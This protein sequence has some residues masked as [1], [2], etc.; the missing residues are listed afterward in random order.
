MRKIILLSVGISLA[1]VDVSPAS[2]QLGGLGKRAKEAVQRKAEQ[3]AGQKID[4]AA[5]K[6]V[7]RSFDSIFGDGS[8]SESSGGKSSKGSSRIFAMLP[9]AATED[10]YDFDAVLT[11]KLE[12]MPKGKSDGNEILMLMHFNSNQPYAGTRITSADPKRKDEGEAFIILD[13]KNESMV[14]L[15]ESGDGKFSM[16]YSWKDAAKYAN[17]NAPSSPSPSASAP[18][19][20]PSGSPPPSAAYSKIGSK[21]IAGYTADGYRQETEQS[22][23]DVWVSQDPSIA[24]SNMMGASSSMKQVRGAVPGSHPG[25]MLLETLTIDKNNGD[26]TLFTVTKIDKNAGVRV[27]MSDY[28]RLGKDSK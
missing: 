8:D 26:K 10:H 28:P 15:M 19:S 7:N 17:N 2:A 20:R 21:K 23:V 3:K 9:N 27:N 4:E 24:F 6:L 5:E 25:G 16:A 22:V 11:Y 14:M 1:L 13:A 18:A 12:N